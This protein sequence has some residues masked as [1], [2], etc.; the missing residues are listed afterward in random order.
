[1]NVRVPGILDL[2]GAGATQLAILAGLCQGPKRCSTH[3]E[4]HLLV[5][6][7]AVRTLISDDDSHRD[8]RA[9]AIAGAYYLM[10][11]YLQK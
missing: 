3:V 6:T 4:V 11:H 8:T 1:M 7:R 9:S 10:N 2:D 5:W